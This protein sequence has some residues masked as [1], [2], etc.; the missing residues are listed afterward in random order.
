DLVS[1]VTDPWTEP[2]VQKPEPNRVLRSLAAS[3]DRKTG[4]RRKCAAILIVFRRNRF[5]VSKQ[6]YRL[7]YQARLIPRIVVRRT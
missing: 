2:P 7:S 1:H 5:V 4:K 3:N 6:I